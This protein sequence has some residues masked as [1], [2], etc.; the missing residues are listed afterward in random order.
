MYLCMSGKLKQT[1]CQ[2]AVLVIFC[3]GLISILFELGYFKY[4]AYTI[5]ENWET[6][7]ITKNWSSTDSLLEIFTIFCLPQLFS[8]CFLRIRF[9]LF[10]FIFISF[11]L[12]CIVNKPRDY[13]MNFKHEAVQQRKVKAVTLLKPIMSF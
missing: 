5:K 1:K 4:F 10:H 13:L 3:D 11:K 12:F 9:F 2:P 6:Q 7:I 8:P